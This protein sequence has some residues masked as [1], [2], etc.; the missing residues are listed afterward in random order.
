MKNSKDLVVHLKDVFDWYI[1]DQVSRTPRHKI[2]NVPTEIQGELVD[3]LYADKVSEQVFIRLLLGMILV[4]QKKRKKEILP[5]LV[6]L[7][8][9]LDIF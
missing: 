8:A 7:R 1:A 9:A 6:D 2:E 4:V 5:A 3:L